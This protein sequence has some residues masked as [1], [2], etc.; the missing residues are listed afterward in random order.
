VT[1]QPRDNPHDLP[2]TAHNYFL[3]FLIMALKPFELMKRQTKCV[4][5]FFWYERPA[6]RAVQSGRGRESGVLVG[7]LDVLWPPYGILGVWVSRVW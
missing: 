1:I 4:C 5:V 3:N 7:N 2:V 6:D